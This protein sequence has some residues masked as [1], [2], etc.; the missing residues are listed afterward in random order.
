VRSR[1]KPHHL[2]VHEAMGN[3][4]GLELLHRSARSG[5]LETG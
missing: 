1:E 4:F 2:A 5:H 3:A